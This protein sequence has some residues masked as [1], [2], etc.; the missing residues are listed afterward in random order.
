[1][2]SLPN[3]VLRLKVTENGCCAVSSL[4]SRQ[5]NATQWKP[6]RRRILSLFPHRRLR[7][8]SVPERH[9]VNHG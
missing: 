6:R 1:M 3:G 9:V 2:C 8:S 5:Q 7:G 4:A